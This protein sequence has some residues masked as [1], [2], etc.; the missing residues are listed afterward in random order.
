MKSWVVKN[1]NAVLVLSVFVGLFM[2][3]LDLL[4]KV[5]AMILI[6]VAIFFSCSHVTIDA[7]KRINIRQA[8]GF[9][10]F[11]FLLIPVPLY[12][13]ALYTVPEYALGVLLI[14]LAP[15]GASSTTLSVL[16]KANSSFCLSST[17]ITNALAPF[18]MALLLYVLEG[19][20]AQIDVLPIFISLGLGIFVPV[21]FY[22]LVVRRFEP[23]K[24]WVRRESQF[25][26]TV[27]IAAMVSVVIALE[28]SYIFTNL[29]AVLFMSVL[30][31]V[32]FAVYYVAAWV[33]GRNMGWEDRKSYMVC[34]GVNNTGICS[35]VAVLYFTAPTIL[36]TIIAEIP[37]ILSFMIFK[38][39]VDRCDG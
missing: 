32:L 11:R 27:C 31:L 34:S 23:V 10:I 17:V 5:T 16:V 2:P 29:D 22:F 38:W 1:F 30:G 21:F 15:V 33:F 20:R 24:L 25:Y 4:P 35:G 9:Y 12:Y 8:I 26:A 3:W 39:Y 19:G 14:S 18:I 37:W 36:F 6:S 28:K 13:M 7:L